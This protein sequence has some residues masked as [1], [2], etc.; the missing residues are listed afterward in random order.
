VT[1]AHANA[2]SPRRAASNEASR[3]QETLELQDEIALLSY[4]TGGVPVISLSPAAVCAVRDGLRRVL[5]TLGD[6]TLIRTI[7]ALPVEEATVLFERPLEQVWDRIGRS[8]E[9]LAQVASDP[10]AES[11][12]AEICR[13]L[14]RNALTLF[15]AAPHAA[16][17]CA[18]PRRSRPR[19]GSW[20]PRVGVRGRHGKRGR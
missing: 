11:T 5:G 1:T 17:A 19:R 20:R 13:V 7:S 2:A 4:C 14:S 9:R 16:S 8:F 6:L 3:A 12:W 18:A 10:T 15:P